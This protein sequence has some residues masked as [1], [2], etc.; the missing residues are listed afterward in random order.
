MTQRDDSTCNDLLNL[1]YFWPRKSITYSRI[2]C[3]AENMYV[4]KKST[5]LTKHKSLKLS[6]EKLLLVKASMD[7]NYIVIGEITG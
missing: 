1:H 5:D 6:L 4:T 7:M 3:V 2:L